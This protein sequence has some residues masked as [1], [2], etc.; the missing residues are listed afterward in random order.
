[1]P[2]ATCHWTWLLLQMPLYTWGMAKIRAAGNGAWDARGVKKFL[3]LSAA[4]FGACVA[5]LVAGVALM[6]AHGLDPA[7]GHWRARRVPRRL[8]RVVRRRRRQ[9]RRRASWS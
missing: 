8:R 5:V 4:F 1:M 2:G 3:A 6:R 9:R 7:R